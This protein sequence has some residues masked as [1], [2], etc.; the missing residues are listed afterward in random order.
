MYNISILASP[1][2]RY[3][4]RPDVPACLRD[5][6]PTR[7]LGRRLRAIAWALGREA[8]DS[9]VVDLEGA[10]NLQG[11][12]DPMGG[13]QEPEYVATGPCCA[14]DGGAA[15]SENES[16]TLVPHLREN[17]HW[18]ARPDEAEGWTTAAGT[19]RTC[20]AV[21]ANQQNPILPVRTSTILS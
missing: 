2:L 21:R 7:G 3:R 18:Y 19:P 12:S 17:T 15:L 6:H 20:R 8:T 10:K 4:D 16:S 14:G 5:P 13:A 1:L 9:I 11:Q